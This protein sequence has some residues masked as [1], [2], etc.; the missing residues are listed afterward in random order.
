M[1]ETALMILIIL[2]VLGYVN[3]PGVT[4]P[5]YHIYA[6]NH[7]VITLN[8]ILITAAIFLMIGF[9]PRFLRII[10]GALLIIWV[11]STLGFINVKG[12]QSIIIISLIVIVIGHRSFHYYHRYRRRYD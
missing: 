3:I 11:I 8:E 7:H 12:L 6:F 4:I 2:Y 5:N 9:A 10:A 1:I